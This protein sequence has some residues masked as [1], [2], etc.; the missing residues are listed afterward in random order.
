MSNG[1]LWLRI[2]DFGNTNNYKYMFT[3][4]QIYNFR[5]EEALFNRYQQQETLLIFI[6]VWMIIIDFLIQKFGNVSTM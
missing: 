1:L 2:R 3:Y 4:V 6:C 5:W